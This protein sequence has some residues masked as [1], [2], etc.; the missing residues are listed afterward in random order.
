MTNR[1]RDFRK[2]LIPLMIVALIPWLAGCNSTPVSAEESEADPSESPSIFSRLTESFTEETFNIEAETPIT[3]RLEHALS[4]EEHSS[5][6]AFQAH[7]DEDLVV[8]GRLLA[9][10]GSQVSGLI[11]AAQRSGKVKGKAEMTVT[12]TTLHVKGKEYDLDVHPLTFQAEGSTDKD[13]KVIAGSAVA[14]AVIGAIAGGKKGAAIGAGTGGGAG[15]AYV[16]TT[17]GKEVKL[18]AEQR[19]RFVLSDSLELPAYS[20]S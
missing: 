18:G 1:A 4:T 10:A 7:L 17:R 14:G 20:D 16:L 15:T 12:L 11:T 5:G 2:L 6:D 3:V 19:V 8:D 13:T 9:P